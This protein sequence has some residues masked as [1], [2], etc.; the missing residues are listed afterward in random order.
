[1]ATV[2]ATFEI[3]N[4]VVSVAW[5]RLIHETFVVFLMHHFSEVLKQT[6]TFLYILLDM[7]PV[8]LGVSR[9][10]TSIT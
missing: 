4:I 3:G 6:N 2:S 10:V 5:D 1:M 7:C 8:R 9:A